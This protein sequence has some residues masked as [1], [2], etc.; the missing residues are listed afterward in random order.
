MERLT[1]ACWIGESLQSL[2]GSY[3]SLLKQEFDV[4]EFHNDISVLS[5]KAFQYFFYYTTNDYPELLKGLVTLCENLDKKLIVIHPHDIDHGLL[6][7]P[8]ITAEYHALNENSFPAWLAQ[9]KSQYF[10]NPQSGEIVIT[11][12]INNQIHS[13]CK[14]S[15]VIDY[16][17]DNV[18]KE[19]TQEEAAAF[20]HYSPTYF[21]KIFHRTVGM[22]FRDYV[23]TKRI[24]LAKKMLTE[25]D[26]TKIAYIAYQC[27]YQDVSYFSRIFKKKTGVSP[28]DYRQQY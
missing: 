12:Q 20:C 21:S 26:S 3:C 10:L 25:D 18:S 13:N 16:I 2:P 8:H 7:P 28:A 1:K 6:P 23:T 5:D 15:K 24:S 11:E 27:G 9:I 4:T 17:D 14:L 19:L 22:C